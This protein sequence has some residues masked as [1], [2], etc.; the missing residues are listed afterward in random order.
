[1][2]EYPS[3]VLVER[4]A[5]DVAPL[6]EMAVCGRCRA[7]VARL[8]SEIQQAWPI[9]ALRIRPSRRGMPERSRLPYGPSSPANDYVVS[10]TDWRTTLPDNNRDPLSVPA[11]IAGW[12]DTIKAERGTATDGGPPSVA[13]GL[14]YLAVYVDHMAAAP[15]VADAVDELAAVARHVRGLAGDVPAAPSMPV[16]ACPGVDDKPCPG[17][18]VPDATGRVLACTRCGSAWPRSAWLELAEPDR[19]RV[20]ATVP[21]LAAFYD[22][23]EG[24]VKR[25]ASTDR[26]P[27]YGTRGMRLYRLSDAQRT[28]ASKRGQLVSE[29]LPA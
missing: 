12:V 7:Y 28:Y 22:V 20:L 8:I 15:W 25:W 13:A 21:E 10:L 18:L 2:S 4:H 23:P 29:P 17:R 26:W 19:G 3:C 1:M 14:A 5:F 16:R 6:P 24:T 11:V 27:R 9:V